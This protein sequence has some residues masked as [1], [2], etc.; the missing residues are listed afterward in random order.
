MPRGFTAAAAHELRTPIAAIRAQ[1]QVAMGEGDAGLRQQAL[2]HT[3]E[4]CDRA[5]RLVERLL[6]RQVLVELV[7][8]AA[9]KPQSLELETDD[10]CCLPGEPTLLAV[11]V[12]NLV[13]NALRYCP[14]GARVVV[15]VSQSRGRVQLRVDDSG[16]GLAEVDRRR[17]GVQVGPFERLGGLAGTVGQ[18]SD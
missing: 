9:T 16:P 13:D 4:G 3:L 12:R 15:G 1:A 2:Q 7:P 8:R 17:L 14:A 18:L 6:P 5:S 10:A 11:L